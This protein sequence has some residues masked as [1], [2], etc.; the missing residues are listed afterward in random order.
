MAPQVHAT[1]RQS[2]G[3]PRTLYLSYDG[4]LEPLGESQVISYLERLGSYDI[5]LL[6]FEKYVDLQDGDRVSQMRARLKASGIRWVHLQYHKWPPVLSTAFDALQ[7]C[8]HAM[9]W[10]WQG[11][12]YLVHA[13][14]YV[15]SLI[16]LVLRKTRGIAFIFDM[17]GFWADEKVD[18]GHWSRASV[19]YRLAKRCERSFFESSDAIV[20]L[21]PAGINII[22][23]L[24]YRIRPNV[25]IEVVPTCTD[26][27]RFTPGPKDPALVSELG[28]AGGLVIGCSGTIDAWYLRRQ[29]FQNLGWLADQWPKSKI[30]ILTREAQG[31]LRHDAVAEGIDPERLV[32]MCVP[33]SEMPRYL[34]LIDLGLFFLK[35]CFSRCGGMATKLGE[36][37]ATGIPVITNA[38]DSDATRIIQEHR[39]GLVLPSPDLESLIVARREIH[40]LVTDPQVRRSCRRAAEQ[41]FS[42]AD[43]VKTYMALY[44]RLA[45]PSSPALVSV[46]A[47]VG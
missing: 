40:M 46:V 23:T 12:S 18:R 42:L 19:M 11:A 22:P 1:D 10:S 21:T 27:D 13:R 8:W 3:I 25:P 26:L 15:A 5:T 29:M 44:N 32:V 28:F 4:V 37:L 7:G 35:P 17:R 45:V 6:S 20:S 38:C 30:F 36:F 39:C 16:A 14:G 47:E 33:F 43:G 31:V 9:V 2:A 34:R 24:G 41:H